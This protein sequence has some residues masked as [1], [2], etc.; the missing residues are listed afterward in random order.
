MNLCGLDMPFISVS[1]SRQNGRWY[2]VL[3]GGVSLLNMLVVEL[4]SSFQ[5]PMFGGT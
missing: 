1:R 3:T 4:T 2:D 5:L